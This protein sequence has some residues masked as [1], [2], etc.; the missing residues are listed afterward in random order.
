MTVNETKQRIEN[1]LKAVA[2]SFGDAASLVKYEVDVEVNVIEGAPEDVTCVLGSLSIGP[3]GSVEDDRLYLPLDAELD[4]DDNVDEE[5]FTRNLEKFKERVENIRERVLASDDYTAEVK[6]I[7]EEFDR[8]MDEKYRAEIEKLNKVAKR[9][10][11]IAA[12]AAAAA[13]IIAIVILVI[14]KLA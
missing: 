12:I 14:D 2:E 6:Q 5:L 7:I 3:E 13:A 4:D 10:L 8:E 1:E 11:T 9:N